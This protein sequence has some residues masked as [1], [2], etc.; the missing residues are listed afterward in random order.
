MTQPAVAAQGVGTAAAAPRAG[1]LLMAVLLCSAPFMALIFTA[2]GPVL[3]ALMQHFASWGDAALLAQLLMTIP[4]IGII[5]A[6]APMGWLVERLGGVAVLRL[7]LL[8]YAL[9]GAAGLF[10]EN[11]PLFFASR[12]ILGVAASG[13]ATAALALVG[14]YFEADGRSRV[15]SYQTAA[16]SAAGFISV[17]AAG[18]LAEVYGWR[19]AFAL[20][21]MGLVLLVCAMVALPPRHLKARSAGAESNAAQ[22]DSGL[23]AL[24]PL[25]GI[26]LLIIVVFIGVFMGAVQMAFLLAAD[27]VTSPAVQSWV[28]ASGAVANSVGALSYGWIRPRFGMRLTFALSLLAMGT[29]HIV[30][31]LPGDVPLKVFG[32]ALA[33][34]GSGCIGPYLGNLLLD[35]AAPAVRGRAAGLLFSATFVGDFLNPLAVTPLR[36]AFGIH[37]AFIGIGSLFV[38]G[39]LWVL[40]RRRSRDDA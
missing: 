36:L 33:A 17:L 26:F 20:Y 9:A 21:L 16:G 37:G 11:L 2:V 8:V 31:G 1:V 6:G 32:A 29:G 35:R 23:A 34:L 24:R 28:M 18:A 15:L 12:L 40:L 39:A 10:L 25:W 4:S 19:V 7:N 22:G 5:V 30:L 27:G 38:A 13:I 14:E 3:P